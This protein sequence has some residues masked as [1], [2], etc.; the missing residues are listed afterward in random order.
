MTRAHARDVVVTV[1]VRGC[2]SHQCERTNSK[3]RAFGGAAAVW[4]SRSSNEAVASRLRQVR[5]GGPCRRSAGTLPPWMPNAGK[6]AFVAREP[7]GASSDHD[8]YRAP[9]SVQRFITWGNGPICGEV[10]HI[11]RGF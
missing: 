11:I 8:D 1:T 7:A 5:T 3:K 4:A 6:G 9:S 2:C 10:E